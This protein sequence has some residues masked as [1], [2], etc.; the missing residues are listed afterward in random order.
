M[1]EIVAAAGT[2]QQFKRG[3]GR[4]RKDLTPT[5][6]MM[7]PN[8]P[9]ET[10]TL[11]RIPVRLGVRNVGENTFH[12]YGDLGAGEELLVMSRNWNLADQAAK[13]IGFV[14]RAAGREVEIVQ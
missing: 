5:D 14:L 11:L 7:T 9:E 12:V 3:P 10:V 1:Q 4:P 13:V 8:A 2:T 6:S